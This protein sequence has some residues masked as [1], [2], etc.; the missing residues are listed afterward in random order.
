MPRGLVRKILDEARERSFQGQFSIS[1]NG[2][3][4]THPEFLEILADIRTAF[5]NNGIVLYSNMVLMDESMAQKILETGISDLHFNFDGASPDS[6][7]FVK[8]NY[9]FDAVRKNIETFFQC[10]ERLNA[11]CTIRVGYITARAYYRG[12][13]GEDAPFVDDAEEILAFIR[14]MLREGDSVSAEQ[15]FVLNGYQHVL[16]RTKREP[17]DIFPSVL[18]G[19]LIAPDGRAYLCCFDFGMSTSLGNVNQ[20]SLHEIWAGEPRRAALHALYTLDY[21]S[22]PPVCRTCLPYAPIN[23]DLYHQVR[24]RIRSAHLSP[25]D[26]DRTKV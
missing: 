8:R 11:S 23:R 1:E 7:D 24:A 5:P 16:N 13:L 20:Q 6:Y 15:E 4:I 2:E 9:R 22:A 17:C 26:R 25:A 12:V 18:K 19:A 14:P 3:A 21:A 10:R